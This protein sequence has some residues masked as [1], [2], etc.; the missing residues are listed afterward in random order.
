M[1]NQNANLMKNYTAEIK[2]DPSLNCERYFS[3]AGEHRVSPMVL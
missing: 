2:Y 3:N 1:V